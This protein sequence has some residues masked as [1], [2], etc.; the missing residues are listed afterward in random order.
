MTQS[1]QKEDGQ[2]HSQLSEVIDDE[3]SEQV[4]KNLKSNFNK[5]QYLNLVEEGEVDNLEDDDEEKVNQTEDGSMEEED[6]HK[7]QK[8]TKSNVLKQKAGRKKRNKRAKSATKSTQDDELSFG[9]PN[10]DRETGGEV[11]HHHKMNDDSSRL[12]LLKLDVRNLLP[13]LELKRM[14]G[15]SVIEKRSKEFRSRTG[16]QRS[17]FGAGAFLGDLRL[18]P[19]HSSPKMELDDHFNGGQACGTEQSSSQKRSKKGVVTQNL[20]PGSSNRPVYFKFVH[21]KSYQG[22]H[23]L[24]LEAVHNG[25]PEAIIDNAQ[26][27]PTHVES[28]I[29]LSHMFRISEDF[30][31]SADFIERALLIFEKGFHPRFNVALANCRLSYR[32]PENRAFFITVFEHIQYLNRRGLRRTPLEYTKL[33]LSLDP[34]NDPLFAVQL[35]DFYSIRSEEYDFL[36][37]FI[38]S[39]SHLAKLPNMN[40]SLALAHFLKSRCTKQSKKDI[41]MHLEKANILLEK[42]LLLFPNFIIPL[43]DACSAEPS[44]ELR[45]CNYFDYS[46]YSNNYKN[47]P[48]SVEV[49]V[50][51]YVQRNSMLWKTKHVLVWLE[52]RLAEMV[53]RFA[54]GEL[55]DEGQNLA[56]WSSFKGPVPRNLL[57]HIVLSDLKIKIP[58]SAAGVIVLDTDPYPPT[59]P[60][61]SYQLKDLPSNSQTVTSGGFTTFLRSVLPSFSIDSDQHAREANRSTNRLMQSH[62]NAA[63]QEVQQNENGEAT[64]NE[65]QESI[66]GLVSSMTNL[67]SFAHD[68]NRPRHDDVDD[69]HDENVGGQ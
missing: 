33:L 16:S 62:S 69:D 27:Y 32:R 24:F 34:E 25:N 8:P 55:Q 51:L 15:K 4:N 58:D 65:L 19:P 20:D 30:K 5:F 67:L 61:I 68:A 35:I 49:L 29:Q 60:L 43:L 40:F 47:V 23:A 66:R 13:E 38:E 57:R 7:Q 44:S 63:S 41:E 37:D 18:I 22:A 48:E 50:S 31:A 26:Y 46:V 21:P 11:C 12:R 39:W 17:R 54:T 2:P 10:N 9:Q 59:E 42:S 6:S 64:L 56:L 3:D 1:I 28:L 45:K 53:N 14:F 52:G 36:I